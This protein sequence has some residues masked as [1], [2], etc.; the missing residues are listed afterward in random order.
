MPNA[1]NVKAIIAATPQI[2]DFDPAT[3]VYA[4][5]DFCNMLYT[6]AVISDWSLWK[7]VCSAN[8]DFRL[9]GNA[10]T[11]GGVKTSSG[12]AI[13]SGSNSGKMCFI[14][15]NVGSPFQRIK[16]RTDKQ[17]RFRAVIRTG[18]VLANTRIFVGLTSLS[19]PKFLSSGGVKDHNQVGV[20]FKASVNS[21]WVV[22]QC[23]SHVSS[24]S[25][26]TPVTVAASTVYDIQINIDASRVAHVYINGRLVSASTAALKT[27][28]KLIPLIGIRSGGA[29]ANLMLYHAQM[30]QLM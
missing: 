17:I 29:K 13:I 25:T 16:W 8:L 15:P 4:R 28:K 24:A 18:A 19:M 10:T 7:S 1:A 5:T 11:Y 9:S 12:G 3:R 26:V 2:G 21:N 6:K 23:V 14:K 20:E 27:T 30:S 22:G